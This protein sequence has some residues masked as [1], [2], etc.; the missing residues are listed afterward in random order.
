MVDSKKEHYYNVSGPLND[1]LDVADSIAHKAMVE[2]RI[3]AREKALLEKKR[4]EME[5]NVRRKA[6]ETAKCD[7]ERAAQEGLKQ[8]YASW[9]IQ[10]AEDF[11]R[12]GTLTSFPR[13]P[14][15]DSKCSEFLCRSSKRNE[16]LRVCCH[17][18]RRF[19]QASG[20]YSVEW[21]KAE[22]IEWHPDKFSTRSH[23]DFKIELQEKAATMFYLLGRLVDEESGE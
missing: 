16:S 8:A 15:F 22:R 13:L 18:L 11:A 5:E 17:D 2:R 4:R 9:R 3:Q 19:L 6:K 20:Q 14:A 7:A 21:L 10:C 12:T 1:Y 23:P